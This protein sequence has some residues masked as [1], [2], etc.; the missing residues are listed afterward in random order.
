M[1]FNHIKTY[2]LQVKNFLHMEDVKVAPRVEKTEVF[3]KG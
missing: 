1:H 3:K 2:Y